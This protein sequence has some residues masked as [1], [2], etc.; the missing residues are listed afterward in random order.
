MRLFKINI[1]TPH[2]NG[3]RRIRLLVERDW[4]RIRIK[5]AEKL[6]QLHKMAIAVL[7]FSRLS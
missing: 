6:F 2:E 5:L 4:P 1:E 3:T 7:R